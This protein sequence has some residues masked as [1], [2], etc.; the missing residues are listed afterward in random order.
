MLDRILRNPRLPWVVLAGLLLAAIGA[1][2]WSGLPLA[3]LVA[4]LAAL[5]IVIALFWSSVIGLSGDS[6]L[7]LEEALSLGSPS[8]EEEQKRAVLRALKDL[9]YER[10][11]GKISED[12]YRELSARYRQ[13]AK[14]L[15]QQLEG[16]HGP[17]RQ[18]AEQALQKRRV[19]AGLAAGEKKAPAEKKKKR[20]A[21]DAP[22]P[23]AERAA[24]SSPEASAEVDSAVVAQPTPEPSAPDAAPETDRCCPSCDARNDL[25]ARFCK[26]C[27]TA[28]AADEATGEQA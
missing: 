22:A 5:L 1:G 4:A 11:V 18:R 17:A 27:G 13:Q 20:K 28:L 6:P 23:A 19:K 9:E 8:A 21:K 16:D 26:R 12:D 24:T 15:L 14:S 2:L 10:S 3:L 25:D 7:T